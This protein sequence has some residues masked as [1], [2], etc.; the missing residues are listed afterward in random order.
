MLRD[1]FDRDGCLY[2][3]SAYDPPYA[4]LLIREASSE[5]PWRVTSFRDGAHI[6][7]QGTA[8][9]RS[10]TALIPEQCRHDPLPRHRQLVYPCAKR[11]RDRIADRRDGWAA[12]R[13]AKPK[14]R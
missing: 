3:V 2:A 6:A 14:R 9:I 13:F 10:D 5:A 8:S 1:T 12:G 7:S 4:L 11:P